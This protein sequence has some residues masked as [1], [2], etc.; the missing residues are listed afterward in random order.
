M[1]PEVVKDGPGKCDICGMD[2]V[3]AESLGFVGKPASNADA[4]IL[5]PATAPL[6]TGTRA[7]V[8]VQVPND[9]GPLFEGREVE[10]GP[11]AGNFYVVKSGVAEG[12]LVVTNGAFK[13]DSEL[14][15]QAKP[16]MMS[17]QSEQGRQDARQEGEA[18]GHVGVF[19]REGSHGE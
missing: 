16:S 3:P 12:E 2:L 18:R 13:L 19:A 8:Y 15:I 10:L 4:P 7:V 1:H 17:P 6:I 14:Q 9:E 5:I 11:R